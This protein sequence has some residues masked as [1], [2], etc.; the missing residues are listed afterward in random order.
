MGLHDT[1]ANAYMLASKD[2]VVLCN[3]TRKGVLTYQQFAGSAATRL[4]SVPTLNVNGMLHPS[5]PLMLSLVF[6]QRAS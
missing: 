3:H 2:N 6:T 1:N 5:E 4:F